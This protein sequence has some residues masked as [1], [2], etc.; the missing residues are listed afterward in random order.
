MLLDL[1]PATQV[2]GELDL[3]ADPD[4]HEPAGKDKARPALMAAVDALNLRFGRD[5]VHLGNSSIAS[6]GHEVRSWSTKQERRSP[7]Y[8]TRWDEMP[9]VKA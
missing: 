5:A 2:Q 6:N 7:R 8:T 9:V 1:Q 4:V 3:F